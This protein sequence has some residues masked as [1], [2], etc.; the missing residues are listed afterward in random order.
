MFL[1]D[2]IPQK[3][4]GIPQEILALWVVDFFMHH[5]IGFVNIAIFL[6]SMLL[7]FQSKQ[8]LS[9]KYLLLCVDRVMMQSSIF[10]SENIQSNYQIYDFVWICLPFKGNLKSHFQSLFYAKFRFPHFSRLSNHQLTFSVAF[11]YN[12]S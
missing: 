5:Y 6:F 11:C 3:V 12:S 9:D 8:W 1:Y 10:A 2:A 7:F 4:D